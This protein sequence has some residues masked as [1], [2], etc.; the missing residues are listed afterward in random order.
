MHAPGAIVKYIEQDSVCVCVKPHCV[1]V[2]KMSK[3]VTF[4]RVREVNK[5]KLYIFSISTK[6]HC[7]SVLW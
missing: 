3:V 1:L 2:L 5:T 4:E 6:Y 7:I